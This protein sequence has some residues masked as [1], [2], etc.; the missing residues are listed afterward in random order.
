MRLTGSLTGK[1]TAVD[2]LLGSLVV[3]G[4]KIRKELGWNPPFT[5]AEGL[6]ETGEWYI[7]LKKL[8]S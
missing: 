8:G 6:K 1:T 4:S 5:M 2:R 3:D 7:G